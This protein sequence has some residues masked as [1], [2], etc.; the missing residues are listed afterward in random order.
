VV[1]LARDTRPSGSALAAAVAAGA[2]ALGA[3]VHDLGELTT[4][5]LHLAVYDAARGALRTS[6]AAAF[7]AH[8]ERLAAGLEALACGVPPETDSAAARVQQHLWLDCANGVG[9]AAAAALASHA[10]LARAGLALTLYN[11]QR[12]GLNARCGADYVQKARSPPDGLPTLHALHALHSDDP[13]LFA[14]LDGDADRA[15]FFEP[16]G[17]AR[18]ARLFDGDKAC[19]LLAS[20]CAAALSAAGGACASLRLGVIQTAYANGGA[21][22]FVRGALAGTCHAQLVVTPTGVKHLHAAAEQFDIACY[23][24]ANGHGSVIFSATARNA[25]SAVAADSASPAAACAAARRLLA[26]DALS[27]PAI[28]DGLANVLLV[29]ACLRLARMEPSDWD[30]L[31]AEL[32]S[33]HVAVRVADRSAVRTADGDERRCVAPAGLQ[34]AVDEA[35]TAAGGAAAARAFVR[36]SGT[37]DVVR[38]YAEAECDAQAD[39]L[40]LAVARAVHRLGVGV[41]DAP[42]PLERGGPRKS[43]GGDDKSV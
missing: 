26:I 27:N 35:V 15:V 23:W 43:G 12:A 14:S 31:Y 13:P 36:A 38:V 16:S 30:A 42:R 25:A 6:H 41:G 20:A 8:V 40:A 2:A 5:A 24:E 33:R 22:R 29:C 19:A 10:G 34:E 3:V 28:G 4:P 39:A 9:A 32:P 17:S 11:T 18:L 7:G 21:A 37:E 1:L